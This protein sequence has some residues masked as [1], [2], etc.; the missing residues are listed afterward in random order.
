MSADAATSYD[1]LPYETRFNPMTHPDRIATMAALHGLKPPP[2]ASCRV[3]ELGT[4]DGSNLLGMAQ[5]LEGATFLG[6]DLASRQI[7][8]GQARAAAL[9]FPN[10]SLR[11]VNLLDVDDSI[12]QFDYIICHGVYSWVPAPVRDKILE[13][14]ARNLVPNGIAYVS[15]NTYPGWHMRGMLR[16]MMLYHTG[17][18]GDPSTRV[19]QARALLQF[20]ARSAK[21]EHS[22]FAQYLRQEAKAFER[23][24]DSYIFHE[25][26]ED[27]NQPVYF[28]EFAAHARS[29]G[30]RYVSASAFNVLDVHLPPEVK[31][32][33]GKLGADVIQREQ[34]LDFI[35]GRLFRH[36]LL[37]HQNL[38]SYA[39]PWPGAIP[40]LRL[41]AMAKPES[42]DPDI[43]GETPEPFRTQHGDVL[44]VDLPLIK[45]ALV[46]LCERW[47]LSFG[48]EELWADTLKRLDRTEA[49]IGADREV[50]AYALL[51]A[52]LSHLVNLHT[53]DPPL[54]ATPGER[55]R[56][57]ALARRAAAADERVVNLRHAYAVLKDF[58]RLVL[59]LLDGARDR[60]AIVA[61]LARSLSEGGIQLECDGRPMTDNAEDRQVLARN[62]N[63]SLER[64]AW[65]ALLLPD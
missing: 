24:A 27:Q 54:A 15:Y 55:P 8:E 31:E 16:E 38:M 13:I 35:M 25:H 5:T 58:D 12:G 56:T 7:V 22:P 61:A 20:V 52:Y 65:A 1:V 36:S 11:A 21:P 40:A 29:H 60:P 57:T 44:N 48:F 2:V 14:C 4:G 9:G 51:Q 53:W 50:F 37:C 23:L 43:G 59:P 46:V 3:L 47:P 10:V 17:E 30:L 63:E 64:I 42:A 39:A 62:V 19:K 41:T 28:H 45:A 32:V 33:L 49:N 34:Y 18:M 6:L 26:L